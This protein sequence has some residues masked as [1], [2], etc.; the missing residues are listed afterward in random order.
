MAAHVWYA[1]G[2]IGPDYELNAAAYGAGV[3]AEEILSGSVAVPEDFKPL[4][5]ILQRDF[6]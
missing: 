2:T 1:G 3:T 6:L 4:Y 5:D